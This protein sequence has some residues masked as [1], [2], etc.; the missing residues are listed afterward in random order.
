MPEPT[1][2]ELDAHSPWLTLQQAASYGQCSDST[3]RRAVKRGRLIAY[4]IGGG[5]AIR[6]HL[7]D[8]ELW[9]RQC[10][11]RADG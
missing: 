10:P 6:I 1:A 4:R 8:F 2:A 5:S 3:V 7:N 9:L 11:T